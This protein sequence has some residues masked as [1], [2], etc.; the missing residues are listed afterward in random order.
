MLDRAPEE[1]H[2]VARIPGSAIIFNV[3]QC[4]AKQRSN[5]RPCDCGGA[6][7]LRGQ[8]RLMDVSLRFESSNEQLEA[9]RG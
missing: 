4:R 9:G 8:F 7:G 6:D 1:R 5:Q 2:P 3:I